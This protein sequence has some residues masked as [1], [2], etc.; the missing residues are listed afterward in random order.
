MVK[1]KFRL[2]VCANSARLY[3]QSKIQLDHQEAVERQCKKVRVL[4]TQSCQILWDRMAPLSREFSRQEYWSGQPFP[5]P[6][7]L[8]DPRI[9]PL[10][11]TFQADS[12][13]SE[14][15]GKPRERQRYSNN[16]NMSNTLA[17]QRKSLLFLGLEGICKKGDYSTKKASQSTL[18]H[19]HKEGKKTIQYKNKS[20]GL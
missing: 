6:G 19:Q 15:P 12:L 13:L 1:I 5:S 10:S 2:D 7:D 17:I 20:L 16:K 18:A 11:C 8:S 14:P 3:F 9:E 4:V